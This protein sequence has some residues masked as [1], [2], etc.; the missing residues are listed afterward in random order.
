M[1]RL[2][3]TLSIALVF[4][5]ICATFVFDQSEGGLIDD[6]G[7]GK[8]IMQLPTIALGIPIGPTGHDRIGGH[9]F[10]AWCPYVRYKKRAAT[11]TLLL[12]KQNTHFYGHHV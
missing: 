1:P 2:S 6:Y 8:Y 9:Y 7:D 4:L 12:G 3:S 11:L 10:H 5:V